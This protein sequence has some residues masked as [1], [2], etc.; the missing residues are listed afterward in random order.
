M[1]E[2]SSPPLR[3]ASLLLALLV[4]AGVAPAAES[5]RIR[6][7]V[8]SSPLAGSQYYALGRVHAE[9]QVGDELGLQREPANRHDPRAIRVDWR[10][11]KLGYLPRSENAAVAAAMD[12]GE[13][14]SARISRLRADPDPWR[15]L[16]IEVF[17]EAGAMVKSPGERQPSRE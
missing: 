11:E 2:F 8:Q 10:G 17:I 7:L 1:S 3:R 13:H 9:M 12:G 5:A 15:R 16:E 14:V 4:A 6:I